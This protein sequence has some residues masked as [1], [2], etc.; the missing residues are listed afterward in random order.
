MTSVHQTQLPLDAAA[1]SSRS[2]TGHR[3]EPAALK[4]TAQPVAP[5]LAPDSEDGVARSASRGAMLLTVRDVEAELQLG[6]TRTYELLRSG[7]IPIIRI[8]PRSTGATRCLTALDRYKLSDEASWRG[9]RRRDAAQIG[10]S[11]IRAVRCPHPPSRFGGGCKT[12]FGGSSRL[13]ASPAPR[14]ADGVVAVSE[15]GTKWHIWRSFSRICLK[16]SG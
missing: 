7:E 16:K 5:R 2:T 10:T 15:S 12:R 11:R 4:A 14:F 8:G 1:A 13:R 6:R 3:W 9:R